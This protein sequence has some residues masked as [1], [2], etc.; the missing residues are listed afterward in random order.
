MQVEA[1]STSHHKYSGFLSSTG[2]V[3][4]V[5]RRVDDILAR[6]SGC[7][8]AAPLD[9]GEI[10][11]VQPGHARGRRRTEDVTAADR[12]YCAQ[13]VRR[14]AAGCIADQQQWFLH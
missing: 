6:S 5:H 9:A 1:T 8:A 14:A 12:R 7:C 3:S 2:I 13:A 11:R 4:A 10:S